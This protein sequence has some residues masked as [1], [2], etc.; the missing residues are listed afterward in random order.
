[1]R[2]VKIYATIPAGVPIQIYQRCLGRLASYAV[3]FYPYVSIANDGGK[4]LVATYRHT[5]DSNPYV[6]GAIWDERTEEYSFHS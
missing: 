6:I 1:M 4:D 2:T 3:D 5:E